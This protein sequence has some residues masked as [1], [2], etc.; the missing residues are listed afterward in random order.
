MKGIVVRWLFLTV[1]IFL[2]AYMID[3]I[4]V[5]GFP[6][7]VLAAAVLGVPAAGAIAVVNA[8]VSSV[9]IERRQIAMPEGL[10]GVRVGVVAVGPGFG[11]GGRVRADGS[12]GAHKIFSLTRR[13]L[14]TD[15]EQGFQ[16]AVR[17]IR[18]RVTESI[19]GHRALGPS[20]DGRP[21]LL[22]RIVETFHA[23]QQFR[24]AEQCAL[25]VRTIAAVPVV[26]FERLVI[27]LERR[28][29]LGFF[30]ILI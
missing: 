3:G 17:A 16:R 9:V 18:E 4:R 7:A 26:E 20:L 22:D 12:N 6:S 30:P 15:P 8:A 5:S 14:R 1:A 27:T 25:I 11:T 10:R 2:A 28:K 24:P 13:L 23:Q 21:V 29:Q 19:Q